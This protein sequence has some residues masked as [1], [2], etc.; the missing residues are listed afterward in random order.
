MKYRPITELGLTEEELRQIAGAETLEGAK[1]LLKAITISEALDA[2]RR[3][4]KPTLNDVDISKD[5]RY[6][7]GRINKAQEVLSWPAEARDVIAK[8]DE[9]VE[10]P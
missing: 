4:S 10:E 6:V 7:M 3:D 1:A 2:D 9:H 5:L 8:H